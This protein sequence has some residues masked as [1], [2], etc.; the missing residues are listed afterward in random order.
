M[1]VRAILFDA[2]G[3]LIYPDP[4]V[5]KAYAS[6]A[7]RFGVEFAEQEIIGRFSTAF[8]RE[9]AI[10][11]ANGGVTSQ[12]REVSRWRAI[13]AD[14]FRDAVSKAAI[15]DEIFADLWRHFAQPESWHVDPEAAACWQ[16]LA[17]RGLLVGIASNFDDRLIEIARHLP[18]LDRARHLFISARIG[19]RKPAP[20]FF[21]A[22]ERD[23]GIEARELLSVGDEFE[24]DYLGAKAAGWQSLLLSVGEPRADVP[25]GD[26]IASM[27]ELPK[28]L[29]RRL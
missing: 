13:V 27:S 24:N 21:R 6:A 22:I 11:R 4:P 19:Y 12:T 3:T 17:E 23:L 14:V 26:I 20:Q 18:P 7:A 5:A 28:C 9:E 1:P 10:G 16:A 8:A 15:C 2:V 29:E 25:T